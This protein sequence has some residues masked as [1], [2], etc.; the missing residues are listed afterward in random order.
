LPEAL[1]GSCRGFLHADGYAGFN[2]L[3]AD[4]PRS[5]NG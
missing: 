4:D 2:I 5:G 3:F 1:L